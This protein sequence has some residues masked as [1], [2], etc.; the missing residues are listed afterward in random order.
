MR[1]IPVAVLVVLYLLCAS[2][3]VF[4]EHAGWKWLGPR[5]GSIRKLVPIPANPAIW[6][7]ISDNHLYVSKDYGQS[8]KPAPIPYAIQALVHPV[9]S[10]IYAVGNWGF[11]YSSKDFG[12]TFQFIS[13]M[14]EWSG[15][16]Q[17]NS[18]RPGVL[19]ATGYDSPLFVSDNDGKKWFPVGPPPID[20]SKPYRHYRGQPCHIDY[21]SYGDIAISPD[22]PD[23]F[24]VSGG[25][26]Y[27]CTYSHRDIL[28]PFLMTTRDF[29]KWNILER[30]ENEYAFQFHQD[31]RM[32]GQ[33]FIQQQ[34]DLFTFS[35]GKLHFISR[36]GFLS[37][38]SVPGEPDQLFGADYLNNRWT[39]FRSKDSGKTWH[40][41]GDLDSHHV[42]ELAVVRARPL[43]LLAGFSF[44]DGLYR[45]DA[46]S[47]GWDASD[48][49]LPGGP[50]EEVEASGPYVY[51]ISPSNS[52]Y[53]KKAGSDWIKLSVSGYYLAV[54][55]K[56]PS[57]L[58]I[59][60]DVLYKSID[61]GDTWSPVSSEQYALLGFDPNDEN[62]FYLRKELDDGHVYKSRIDVFDPQAIGAT[63]QSTVGSIRIHPYNSQLIFFNT[64]GQMY[65]SV[66]GGNTAQEFKVKGKRVFGV[67]FYANPNGYFAVTTH[68]RIYRTDDSGRTYTLM[69]SK[70]RIGTLY[71]CDPE[72]K[73]LLGRTSRDKPLYESTDLA[74]TWLP[75]SLDL[76]ADPGDISCLPNGRLYVATYNGIYREKQTSDP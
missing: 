63:F 31:G 20:I 68:N 42:L 71:N 32:P 35:K 19:Y 64:S 23:E 75:I 14:P 16:L 10:T 28:D 72:G 65:R 38:S 7:T 27:S 1:P 53:R 11:V 12:K 4:A 15:T 55:P 46:T 3:P 37:L 56:K 67:A 33:L 62:A 49:G 76:P 57:Q 6:L 8:W 50:A 39:I 51:S 24:L 58:F 60:S 18:I 43:L 17:L 54:N 40:K 74:R 29:Y 36:P 66:D 45:W 61:A 21:F 25:P 69:R 30:R 48:S 59:Q 34:E 2:V 70:Y 9:T 13:V 5:G 44:Y 73:R 26:V 22:D 41:F 52:L 47:P